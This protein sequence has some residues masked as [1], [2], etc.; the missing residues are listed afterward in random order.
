LYLSPFPSKSAVK[1]NSHAKMETTL[2]NELNGAPYDHQ[3]CF[4]VNISI[5]FL[6]TPS[7]LF[8]QDAF[9]YVSTDRRRRR[10]R[11]GRRRRS[12][13]SN[14][15]LCIAYAKGGKKLNQKLADRRPTDRTTEPIFTH[16]GS[17]YTVFAQ[18]VPLGVK[19]SLEI[20]VSY[21][22]GLVKGTSMQ[23]LFRVG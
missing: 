12:H 23:A 5:L 22:S 3:T 1:L 19:L 20:S 14:T 13:R 2:Q 8:T 18:N 7:E 6:L 15:A 21:R 17:H 4:I 9:C 10:R 16:N 11:R